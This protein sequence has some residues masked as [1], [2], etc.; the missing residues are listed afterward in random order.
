MGG[1]ELNMGAPKRS[2]QPIR[3][4]EEWSILS[5]YVIFPNCPCG[6]QV[7]GSWSLWQGGYLKQGE[8]DEG[9]F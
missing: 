9:G 7:Q 3:T 6:N 4:Q 8:E 2:A 1:L 5:S